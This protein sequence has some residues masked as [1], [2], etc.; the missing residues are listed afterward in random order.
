MVPDRIDG[1]GLYRW[2]RIVQIAPDCVVY[3]VVLQHASY[4]ITCIRE[5]TT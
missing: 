4:W 5:H 3:I 2:H 1:T